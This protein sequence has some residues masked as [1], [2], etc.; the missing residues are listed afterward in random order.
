M[1]QKELAAET[2]AILKQGFYT[3]SGKRVDISTAHRNAVENSVLI[4]PEEAE[5]IKGSLPAPGGEKAAAEVVNEPV[6]G[7]LHRLSEKQARGLAV[8]NFASAK[9]PGGGFIN[10][11]VAQEESLAVASGLYTT[12][13]HC[14][15]YYEANRACKTMCYT[16]H[17]IFSPDVVFF[18]GGGPGLLEQPFTASVLTLPAVNMG[19]VMQRGED[20]TMAKSKMRDRQRLALE[21]LADRGAKTLVLGAYG[22]GVFRNDPREVA[23]NWKAL[24]DG[25]LDRYFEKIYFS[26]LARSAADK[27]Y[28]MFQ[29]TFGGS[30]G[31]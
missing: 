3:I 30:A 28:K 4:T 25:G 20:L 10:G 12:Q 26:I 24:L 27:N 1:T 14:P 16:D 9:N 22:C 13:C 5:T 23:E 18:R 7:L 19:Q 11:A 29:E 21:L 8:L 17:A 15:G 2:L 6:T 31:D